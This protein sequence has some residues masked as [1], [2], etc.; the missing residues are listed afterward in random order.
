M[1]RSLFS[2]EFSCLV[3]I[4]VLNKEQEDIEYYCSLAEDFCLMYNMPGET[5]LTVF[6]HTI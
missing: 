4:S 2:F 3:D 5:V 6:S 1:L